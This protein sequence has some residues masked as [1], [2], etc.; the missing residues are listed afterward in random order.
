MR[1]VSLVPSITETLFDFGLTA[2]EIVGRTK[3][4]IHPSDEVAQVA[5]IG[6]TKN[7]NI[8]KIRQLQP[9][10]IIANKEENQ[11]DQVEQLMDFCKVWVTDI[12]TIQDNHLFIQELGEILNKVEIAADFNQRISSIINGYSSGCDVKTAY[13]IWRNPYMTTGSDTFINEIMRLIG[14]KNIFDDQQ[15]YP[16]ISI[17]EMKAADYILLSSE[18]YPFKQKHIDELQLHLPNK[19]YKLVDGEAFSWFGTHILKVADYLENLHRE[20]HL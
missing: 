15:R 9:D 19:R 7:L 18:P 14:C 11:K 10:L 8:D 16:V 1:I 3:F 6:G 12:A 13:L 20:I 4:C 5:I 2:T 17:E